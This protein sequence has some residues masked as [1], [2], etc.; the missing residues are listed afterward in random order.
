MPSLAIA[1]KCSFGIPSILVLVFLATSIRQE[2][3][4]KGIKI[5]KEEN[6]HYLRMI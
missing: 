3:K 2:N 4:I 6:C 1:V 5:G